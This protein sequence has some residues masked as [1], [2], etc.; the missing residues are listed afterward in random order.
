MPRA[1]ATAKSMLL[2]DA[3][4]PSGRTAAIALVLIVAAVASLELLPPNPRSLSSFEAMSGALP[5]A[6]ATAGAL[7]A[8]VADACCGSWSAADGSG[9]DSASFALTLTCCVKLKTGGSCSDGGGG[10][11]SPCGCDGEYSTDGGRLPPLPAKTYFTHCAAC[12][13]ATTEF[14]WF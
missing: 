1:R 7:S 8:P 11:R 2:A 10:N 12:W 6:L 9:G 5:A 3:S 4:P 14:G 13:K